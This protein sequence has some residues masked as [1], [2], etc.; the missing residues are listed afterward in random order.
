MIYVIQSATISYL[1]FDFLLRSFEQV[2]EYT[3]NRSGSNASLRSD[4]ID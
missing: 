4:K 3:P 2:L 1:S